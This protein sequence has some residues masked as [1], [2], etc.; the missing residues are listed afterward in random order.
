MKASLCDAMYLV[1]IEYGQVSEYGYC[2]FFR[3][4]GR[5]ANLGQASLY[6]AI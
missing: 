4:E 1:A 6:R 3:A 2:F 5:H